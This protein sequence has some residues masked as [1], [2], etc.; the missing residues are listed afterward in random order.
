VRG[1]RHHTLCVTRSMPRDST[2]LKSLGIGRILDCLSLSLLVCEECSRV[3]CSSRV[4]NHSVYESLKQRCPF[5][6]ISG[7][8]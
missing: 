1:V 3:E 7:P 2:A 5:N 6:T 4:S 8:L